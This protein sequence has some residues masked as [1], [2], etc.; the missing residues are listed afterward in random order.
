VGAD[1]V[2]VLPI[3]GQVVTE[4]MAARLAGRI[5]ALSQLADGRKRR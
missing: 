1:I 4:F 5:I 3:P 2:E